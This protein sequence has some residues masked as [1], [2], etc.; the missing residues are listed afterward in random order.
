MQRGGLPPLHDQMAD[1]W[2]PLK[3]GAMHAIIYAH[4]HE[5]VWNAQIDE[6]YPILAGF[7]H[8]KQCQPGQSDDPVLRGW[9][10]TAR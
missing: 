5:M 2:G 7:D 9:R 8:V 4:G 1:G 3:R 6:R 10:A